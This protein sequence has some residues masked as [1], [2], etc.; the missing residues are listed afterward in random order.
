MLNGGEDTRLL[1]LPS[2]VTKDLPMAGFPVGSELERPIR[3][4]DV[5]VTKFATDWDS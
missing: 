2:L 3:E 4:S 5:M 1:E